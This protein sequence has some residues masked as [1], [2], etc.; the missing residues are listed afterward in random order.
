MGKNNIFPRP[1]TV[2]YISDKFSDNF[3]WLY[4]QEKVVLG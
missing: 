2:C 1:V 4:N 3:F